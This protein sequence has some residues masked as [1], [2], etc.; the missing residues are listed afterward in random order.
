MFQLRSGHRDKKRIVAVDD[1]VVAEFICHSHPALRDLTSEFTHDIVVQVV[2]CLTYRFSGGAR[3][4][5]A[6]TGC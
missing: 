6:G 1:E 5:A 2:R 4:L 3:A